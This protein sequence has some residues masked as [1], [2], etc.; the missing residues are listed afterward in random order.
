MHI[1]LE[2]CTFLFPIIVHKDKADKLRNRFRVFS[3]LIASV[4]ERKVV[5]LPKRN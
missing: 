3:I 4:I 1:Y 5:T 2:H